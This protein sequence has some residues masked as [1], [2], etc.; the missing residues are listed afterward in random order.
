[1]HPYRSS[2]MRY[3]SR[4]AMPSAVHSRVYG[5]CTAEAGVSE[6]SGPSVSGCTRAPRYFYQ[7]PVL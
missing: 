4:C 3:A 2:A 6:A 5:G 7:D 1:M